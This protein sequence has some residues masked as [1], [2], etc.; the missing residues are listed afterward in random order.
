MTEEEIDA[1]HNAYRKARKSYC[2]L[3][4]KRQ[5]LGRDI[6]F[7]GGLIAPEHNGK[8]RS[9]STGLSAQQVEKVQNMPAP[10]AILEVMTDWSEAQENLLRIWNSLPAEE[11]KH[12][13]DLPDGLE[14]LTRPFR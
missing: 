5:K 11:R 8:Y 2:D 13:Q 12:C 10:D 14:F 9:Q 4:A 3:D 1:L 7:I 6:S